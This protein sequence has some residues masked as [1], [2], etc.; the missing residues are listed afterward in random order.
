[1]PLN[2][3]HARP[4]SAACTWAS[5]PLLLIL[6]PPE[7]ISTRASCGISE[8]NAAIWPSPK[9]ILVG[10]WKVKFCIC[11]VVGCVLD[12]PLVAD[13][14][15]SPTVIQRGSLNRVSRI[16]DQSPATPPATNALLR[17]QSTICL[18]SRCEVTAGV[19]GL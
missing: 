11:P 6:P 12:Q 17:T 19:R 15:V 3:N 10:L 18:R 13:D 7:V 2:T 5:T 8:F 9:M 1:M 4:P 14:L 16:G